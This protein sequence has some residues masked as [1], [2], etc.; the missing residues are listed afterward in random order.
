LGCRFVVKGFFAPGAHAG[1]ASTSNFVRA[2]ERISRE[3]HAANPIYGRLVRVLLQ[4][5]NMIME[6]QNA[7]G[8]PFGRRKASVLP[9]KISEN[10]CGVFD[11]LC[12]IPALL[13]NQS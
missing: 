9:L 12:Y 4:M 13:T 5:A 1:R 6:F 7:V 2:S 10:L 11:A 3:R 8:G